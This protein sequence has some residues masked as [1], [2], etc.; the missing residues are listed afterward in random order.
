MALSGAQV[1][2]TA[3]RRCCFTLVMK[4]AVGAVRTAL[5][6]LYRRTEANALTGGATARRPNHCS[7]HR[8]GERLVPGDDGADVLA[9]IAGP[10]AAG[11][12][13]CLVTGGSSSC[14]RRPNSHP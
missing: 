2:V 6:A 3:R 7:R 12:T 1:A 14:F 10:A 11:S 5:M 9:R 13:T 8:Q 4:A